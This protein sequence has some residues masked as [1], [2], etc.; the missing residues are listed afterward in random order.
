M[1]RTVRLIILVALLVC[2]SRAHAQNRTTAGDFSVEPPTL[3]SLGFDWKI[4]G[5][6]NRNAHVEVSYRKK[7]D[8][9][10]KKGLPLLRLQREWVNGG[11]AQANDNPLLPRT[12]FDYVVPNMFSGSLLNLEPDTEYECRFVLTD[13]DG[14]TGVATRSAI[15]RTRKS[16]MP[17]AGGKPITCIPSDWK[18]PKQ[19]PAFTGLMAAYYMGTS[20]YDYQNAYPAARAARRHHPRARRP[21]VSDRFH[22]MN[23]AARPGYLSLGTVFDGTY[24]LTAER[25]AGTADRDQGRRRRRSDLRRRRRAEPVQPDGRELQLL[26]RPRRSAIPNVAFLLGIKNIAGSQRLH[27]EALAASTT[28]AARFRTT[29]RARRTTTSPTTSFIGRH[30]PDRMMGWIGAHLGEVPGLPRAADV[31]VRDQGLRPGPRRRPQLHRALARRHR[32]RDVRQSRRHAERDRDRLPVSIDFYGNDI[33]NMGDNCIESDGGAH[34]IRV[35]R[36][37]CFNVASQALQRAADVRRARSTSIQN[38]VYNAPASGS[39]KFVATPAGVLVYQN[40]FIGDGATRAGPR[41]TCTSAT[42]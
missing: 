23:G 14:V 30:D 8:S 15:V 24:Y 27:A 19:E 5:D 22:Y 39:L 42:T 20:H 6:D 13:P 4:A 16:R 11:P 36:N 41:R 21:Y 10:W 33:F 28:S 40:T 34:N 2:A 25:H 37:R 29:G 18:A 7:S 31:R 26:R 12:P 17:A 9:A 38:L 32:R 3:L 1:F 35:F